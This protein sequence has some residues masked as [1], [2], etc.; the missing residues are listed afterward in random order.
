MGF[1]GGN[2]ASSNSLSFSSNIAPVFNLGDDNKNEGRTAFAQ[3]TSSEATAKDEMAASVGVGVGGG[4]GS[5][6]P[7]SLFSDENTTAA[8]AKQ[9]I[10]KDFFKNSPYMP[11]LLGLGGLGLGAGGYYLLKRK[12]KKKS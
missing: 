11:V 5:G 12:K 10:S 4:S 2:S 3:T 1:L 7:A 6:G 8:P 9:G